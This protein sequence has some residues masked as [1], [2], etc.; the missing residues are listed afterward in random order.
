[1]KSYI[2]M[3]T[4]CNK[5]CREITFK[6]NSVVRPCNDVFYQKLLDYNDFH[7]ENTGEADT[8]AA[9]HKQFTNTRGTMEHKKKKEGRAVQSVICKYRR[10][11]QE[12][13]Q[14]FHFPL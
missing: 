12:E 10:S 13:L 1:M 2:Y 7:K 6:C 9:I 14:S 11:R 8:A 5:V 4:I 3:Q